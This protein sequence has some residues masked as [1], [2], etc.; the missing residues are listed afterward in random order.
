MEKRLKMKKIFKLFVLLVISVAIGTGAMILTYMLPTK[1]IEKHAKSAVKRYQKEEAFN[2]VF[3][4][5]HLSWGDHFTDSI[6]IGTAICDSKENLFDRAMKNQ[7]IEYEGYINA[8]DSLIYYC[9]GS[10]RTQGLVTLDENDKE[11]AEAYL[12]EEEELIDRQNFLPFA[13]PRYWNGYVVVLKAF[14]FLFD[15]NVLYVLNFLCQISLMLAV[16]YMLWKRDKKWYIIPYLLVIAS[17]SP[18]TTCNSIQLSNIMYITLIT[19]LVMLVK[20]SKLKESTYIYLFAVNGICIAYFDLLTYPLLAL[21]M[22][23]VLYC[24]QNNA[25]SVIK[26]IVDLLKLSLVWLFSYAL[27]WMSKWVLATF[28][29]GQNVIKNAYE[30][31]LYRSGSDENRMCDGV[32]SDLSYG[33]S[34]AKIKGVIELNY[35]EVLVRNFYAYFHVVVLSIFFI[36]IVLELYILFKYRKGL[37]RE[38]IKQIVPFVFVGIYPFVWFRLLINHSFGHYFYVS[39]IIAVVTFALLCMIV[40]LI[41]C[42]KNNLC[43]EMVE[44]EIFNENDF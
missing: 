28:I 38:N 23:L 29:T 44:G 12:S 17:L 31:F 10:D 37:K 42:A 1:R 26:R 11:M 40:K 5:W 8:Y 22:P 27:M 4:S 34:R 6:M 33:E 36:A 21:G 43:N 41:E 39:R 15:F 32:I 7:R 2:N 13:Y 24:V 19:M 30:A 3:D 18:Y 14:L 20:E 16:A 35:K 25:Y 9:L